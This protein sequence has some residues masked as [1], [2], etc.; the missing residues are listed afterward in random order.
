MIFWRTFWYI[1]DSGNSEG[2][3]SSLRAREVYVCE[4]HLVNDW[5]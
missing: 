4:R 3:H 1:L 5:V 2:L